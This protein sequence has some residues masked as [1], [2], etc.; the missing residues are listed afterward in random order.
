MT[1]H[2]ILKRLR[3][4]TENEVLKALDGASVALPI[5][6]PYEGLE[7]YNRMIDLVTGDRERDDAAETVRI[8]PG[9]GSTHDNSN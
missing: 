2:E 3:A 4:A 1:D 5:T 7:L 9:F 8:V 6:T